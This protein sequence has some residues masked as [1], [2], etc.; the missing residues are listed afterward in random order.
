MDVAISIPQD[1]IDSIVDML[2]GDPD[3]LKNCAM[4]SHSF[5][6]PSRKHLFYSVHLYSVLLSQKLHHLLCIH[7]EISHCIKELCITQ[8]DPTYSWLVTDKAL[9]CILDMLDHLQSL[10]LGMITSGLIM[11][12]WFSRELHSALK[13]RFQSSSLLDLKIIQCCDVPVSM[14]TSFINLRRLILIMVHFDDDIGEQATLDTISFPSRLQ[15][16]E[17]LGM[18]QLPMAKFSLGLQLR[19]LSVRSSDKQTL[20]VAQEVIRC[21]TKSIN[22]IM[23]HCDDFLPECMFNSSK[24][25][26]PAS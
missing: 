23:W 4:T 17:L 12:S 22:S 1:V 21:S 2:H 9:P 8:N 7:P 15:A 20:Y 16:L 3:T 26:I 5:L 25:I 13:S 10:S 19:L 18:G 24:S 11:W 14:I 6:I